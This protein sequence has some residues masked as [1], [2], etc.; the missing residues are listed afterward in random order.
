MPVTSDSH[1]WLSA[2]AG[3][4]CAA[5]ESAKAVGNITGMGA[6]FSAFVAVSREGL[7]TMDTDECIDGFSMHL[8]LMG[9]PPCLA[10]IGGAEFDVL[11]A[12]NLVDMLAAIFASPAI[13]G[14]GA[15]ACQPVSLA[16]GFD[17][18]KRHTECLGYGCVT[19]IIASHFFYL[20]FL[21]SGHKVF[22][23]SERKCPL[24]IPLDRFGVSGPLKTKKIARH[25]KIRS[26][27]SLIS[28]FTCSEVASSHP[29]SYPARAVQSERRSR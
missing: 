11:F 20:C 19:A 14:H 6:V 3:S 17:G 23:Q 7:T 2:D 21:F 16:I 24:T 22:L 12:G 4:R 28:L 29:V 15:I 27:Q 18:A 25:G 9:I 5:L 13:L 10:A 26:G 8:M 1:G